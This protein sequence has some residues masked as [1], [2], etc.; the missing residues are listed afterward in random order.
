MTPR[1]DLYAPIDE[2]EMVRRVPSG[3]CLDATNIMAA[4]SV[5]FCNAHLLGGFRKGDLKPLRDYTT[6]IRDENPSDVA[7]QKLAV[8]NPRNVVRLDGWISRYNWA[9]EDG[10]EQYA[11]LG[12]VETHLK[13]I[14]RSVEQACVD[15]EGLDPGPEKDAVLGELQSMAEE[16][17]RAIADLKVLEVT[18]LALAEEVLPEIKRVLCPGA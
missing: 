2:V 5:I 1:E 7:A 16:T 6:Y 4:A 9:L 15:I 17:R 13:E 12:P 18:N 8:S 11:S 10:A 14:L 3:L